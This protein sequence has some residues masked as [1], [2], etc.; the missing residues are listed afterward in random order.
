MDRLFGAPTDRLA[1]A[2]AAALAA[3]LLSL[4]LLAWRRPVL[5][6]LGLR[7][8]PRR[9]L[10]SVLIVAGLTTSTAVIATAIG[11]GET[12]AGTIRAAVAG[13]I[14]PVDEVIVSRGAAPREPS[15]RDARAVLAGS[16]LAAG[17][18]FRVS[19]YDRLAEQFLDDPQIAALVPATQTQATA[20]SPGSSRARAGVNVVGLPRAAPV[21]DRFVAEDGTPISLADL[22]VNEALV[23]AEAGRLLELKAGDDLSLQLGDDHSA[24]WRVRA[25]VRDG[26]LAGLQPAVLAPLDA[27]QFVL[28]RPGSI[29]QIL[30]ANRDRG[31]AETTSRL[32]TGRLRL[33]LA[34]PDLAARI[35]R[36]L[37]SESG[38]G[39]LRA[40]EARV[41][42]DVKPKIARLREVARSGQ[43]TPE[44]AYYLADPQLTNQYRW[45]LNSIAGDPGLRGQ[46]LIQ[47]VAPL[48]VV[49]VKARAISAANE[50]GSA[51]TTVFLILGLF[52]IAASLL[53]VF[54]IFVMLAAERRTEMGLTRAVVAQRRHLVAAF[55]VEGLVYDLAAAAVGLVLGVGIGVLVLRLVQ[56]VL[57]RWDV[58]VRGQMSGGGIVLSFCLGA[59][60]TFATVLLAAW[61]VSRVNVIAAIHG[62]PDPGARRH[63]SNVWWFRRR[64]V[65]APLWTVPLAVGGIALIV[66]ADERGPRLAAG[67]A[68][69]VLAAALAIR[70]AAV[71]LGARPALV[72]R[73]VATVAGPLIALLFALLPSAPRYIRTDAIIRSGTAGFVLAGVAMALSLVW[74][75]GRNLDMLLAPVR[76]LARPFGGLAPATRMAVAYPLTHPFRTG[77]TAAMFALVFLTMVAATALLRSTEVAYV[78]RDGGAGFD[79]RALFSTPPSDFAG[80]LAQSSSIRPED[81]TAIGS[82]ALSPLEALWPGE[83]SAAWKPL[84]VRT[85]D[86]TLLST[87][88]GGLMLRAYGYGSD[89]S[90]WRALRDHPGLAI[91][92][93]HELDNLPAARTALESG[94]AGVPRFEPTPV[95]VR[96]PR[97]GVAHK[98]IIIGVAADSSILTGGVLTSRSAM[99]GSPAAS[100]PADEFFLRTREDVS[101]RSAATGVALT[102]P[103]NGVRTRVLGEEARTGQAVRQLLDT[104]IRGFLGMGLAAGLAALGVIGMRSVGERRQQ[105]GML[106]A[107]GFSRRMVQATFLIE[108][109]VVAVLGIT[110]GAVVGLVLAHNV[111]SFLSRDFTQLRL[112]VP[113]W[114]VGAIAIAAYSAALISAMLVAWQ[115]G[116]VVPA[117]ALRYE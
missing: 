104:L 66:S 97:G 80:A 82:Q 84:E 99:A 54:L 38:Q 103:A 2:A 32:V 110:V 19:A 116:R 55:A 50:Y 40:L 68:V 108:G 74:V 109:S 35:A 101:Y 30:I 36:A 115:A 29:N 47:R 51:V 28:G 92:S 87:S 11:T 6:R 18:F 72:D 94:A 46:E 22:E 64:A 27:L 106:R 24:V 21:F 98:L 3:V 5:V 10:R 42:P 73:L 69:L 53:L 117:E 90:V 33:A 76:L 91:A 89:E 78:K 25:V 112:I 107:I 16:D 81:F 12:M 96:D 86:D 88:S 43:P 59:L 14:G 113:W 13:G 79:I 83:R 85:A 52:S 48:T 44:L 7:A 95:W 56:S 1:F 26:G 71:A 70:A 114:Q 111:V 57:D 23:N 15:I 58:P 65:G 62:S 75:A 9:M 100:Q 17:E 67:G 31:D 61:R 39:Q 41:R 49:D 20:V 4:A 45:I 93:R 34:D 63:V 105:I 77:L 102:F 8:V 60:V 37:A